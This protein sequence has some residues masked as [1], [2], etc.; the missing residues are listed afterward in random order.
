MTYIPED[1]KKSARETLKAV[2]G[3]PDAMP[4]KWMNEVNAIEVALMAERRKAT[5][6]KPISSAPDDGTK[7]IGMIIIK[8]NLL[9]RTAMWVSTRIGSDTFSGWVCPYQHCLVG[10]FTHWMPLPTLE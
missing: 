8:G 4:E 5:T 10:P 6:G 3:N 9:A 2:I 1:I 7:I